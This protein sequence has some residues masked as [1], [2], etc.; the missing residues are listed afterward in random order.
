MLSLQPRHLFAARLENYSC[1]SGIG[2]TVLLPPPAA[3]CEQLPLGIS[4]QAILCGWR[5]PQPPHW[6]ASAAQH[7]GHGHHLIPH[8]IIGCDRDRRRQWAG[9]ANRL[10]PGVENESWSSLWRMLLSVE[11]TANG[12]ATWRRVS[13]HFGRAAYDR[14]PLCA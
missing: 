11:D 4:S 9:A 7:V 14:L 5:I 12:S 2:R 1:Y 3:I 10:L 8:L 13:P 6:A